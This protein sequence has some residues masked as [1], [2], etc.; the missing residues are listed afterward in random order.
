MVAMSYAVSI[1][2]LDVSEYLGA[3]CCMILI[4]TSVALVLGV[5]KSKKEETREPKMELYVVICTKQA[6]K[7]WA[8]SSLFVAHY[9]DLA[10]AVWYKMFLY[11]ACYQNKLL[12]SIH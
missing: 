7:H 10:S 9:L 6:M 4:D 11:L 12:T 3:S 5:D 8:M 1:V 2:F